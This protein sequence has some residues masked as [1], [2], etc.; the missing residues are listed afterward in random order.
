MLKRSWWLIPAALI[1][2]ATVLVFAFWDTILIYAAPKAVLSNS[3]MHTFGK[4]QDRI[5][6]GPIPVLAN[7]ID[8][9]GCNTIDFTLD[10]ANVLLGPV[11]YDLNVQT[12][13]SPRQIYADGTVKSGDRLLDISVFLNRD[14]AAVSS[15]TLLD[16][17]FYGITYDTFSQDIRGIPL[18]SFF[19]GEKLIS[20]WEESVRD[21][22]RQMT[23]TRERPQMS[24]EQMQTMLVGILMLKP[25]VSSAHMYVSGQERD[26]HRISFSESGPEIASAAEAYTDE[27]SNEILALLD[28]LKG[29]P[30]SRLNASFFLYEDT[31]IKLTMEMTVDDELLQL[32]LLPGADPAKDDLKL[33][34]IY[35][36]PELLKKWS[37]DL[38]TEYDDSRYAENLVIVSVENGIQN[39]AVLDYAWNRVNGDLHL[40]LTEG[41][42]TTDVM[43][44]LR[45]TETGFRLATDQFEDLMNLFRDKKNAGNSACVMHISKGSSITAPEYKN[46][47]QWSAEDLLT[48]LGGLGGLLGVTIE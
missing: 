36:T 21:L 40:E 41:E 11:Q 39:R 10:T 1:L 15:D 30:D 17:N 34:G 7:G 6:Q 47:D 19:L 44:N 23:D 42:R 2:I 3:L 46:L 37:C 29:D 45:G 27:I 13:G 24:L 14:Y 33:A 5:E 32:E 22:Q 31:I 38:K 35:Q 26:V 20:Q 18:L 12:A 48:L 8:G 28:R 9:S 4:I 16:S 25:K 43:F